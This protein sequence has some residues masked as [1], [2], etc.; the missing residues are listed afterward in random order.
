M[1]LNYKDWSFVKIHLDAVSKAYFVKNFTN[2]DV[3]T[4]ALFLRS[5][6][7]NT[8]DAILPPT[9]YADIMLDLLERETDSEVVKYIIGDV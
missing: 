2:F 6:Y 7:D 9:E 8:R 5:L 3:L 1:I 4:K